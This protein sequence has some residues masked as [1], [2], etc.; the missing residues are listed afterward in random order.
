MTCWYEPAPP[1]WP[2]CG[3]RSCCG[4][5]SA[6]VNDRPLPRETPPR[7]RPRC[8]VNG[9][10]PPRGPPF[11]CSMYAGSSNWIALAAVLV[12]VVGSGSS[13]RS[14]VSQLMLSTSSSTSMSFACCCTSS[15]QFAVA[16]NMMPMCWSLPTEYP[17]ASSSSL[18]THQRVVQFGQNGL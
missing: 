5:A 17:L 11:R 13:N 7:P 1:R 2:V 14:V 8:D 16:G 3:L 12:E 18:S 6:S 9:R 4:S 15:A 10:L